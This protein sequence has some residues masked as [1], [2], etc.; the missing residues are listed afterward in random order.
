M[1]IGSRSRTKLAGAL[2]T[3]CLV[4]AL[5][6]PAPAGAAGKP[7]RMLGPILTRDERPTVT[8]GR[9]GGVSVALPGGQDLWIFGDTPRYQFAKGKWKIKG[10]VTGSSAAKGPY[11]RGHI[12]KPM[13]EIWVGHKA[14]TKYPAS[15]FIPAPTNLYMP[16]GSGRPCT[17]A[18]GGA[19][20]IR[21]VT[22]AA[23]LPNR[24]YVLVTYV[25]DCVATVPKFVSEGYGFMVYNWKTNRITVPPVD[26]FKPA[27]SGAAISTINIFGSPIVSKGK[28]TLFSS[29]CCS[30]GHVYTVTMPA[31]SAALSNPASYVVH[32]AKVA[33]SFY[34]TVTGKTPTQP[35]VQL[36]ELS[37]NKGGYRLYTAPKASGPWK[38]KATG[39]LPGCKTAPQACYSMVT[40]PELSTASQLMVSY[41]LPGYGPGVKG[42][43]YPHPPINHLVM[44]SIH[45]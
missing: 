43:P 25:E 17:K 28:V 33:P 13:N 23:L 27:T 40:H 34:V 21:W 30:P 38:R 4:V 22:G 7:T 39:V 24:A 1:R 18:N 5:A 26:V 9:D 15:R 19:E 11:S 32:T 2:V 31:T 6:L 3:S 44:A 14:S 42:H 10:F 20:E 12:P 45:Y 16:D 37:N 41:Y 35:R 29:T 8:L 36:F